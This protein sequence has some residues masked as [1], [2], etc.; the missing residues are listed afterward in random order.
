MGEGLGIA[1]EDDIDM[2]Q[3]AVDAN[4]VFSGDHEVAGGRALLFRTI[5]GVGADVD[6]FLGVAEVIDEAIALKEGVVEVAD[7]GA[8]VFAGGDGAPAADGVEADGDCAV[9]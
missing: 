2:A 8:E 3:I 7:D 1:A 6:D 9:G 4:T 5:L